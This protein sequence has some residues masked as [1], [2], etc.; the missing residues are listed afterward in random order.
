MYHMEV[1]VT[2]SD[3]LIFSDLHAL[4]W[5]DGINASLIVGSVRQS[6]YVEGVGAEARFYY[7][8]GFTRLNKTRIVVVDYFNHCLRL[9]AHQAQST[10][11]L[12]GECE[13]AGFSDGVESHF[14]Y[15][16]SVI[17]HEHSA[18][19]LIIADQSNH[20]LRVFDLIKGATETIIRHS[21]LNYPRAI[22]YDINKENLLLSNWNYIC[23]YNLKT[24]TLTNI[25]GSIN[26]GYAD[27]SLSTTWLNF[28][29]ELI[30]ITP[31][32]TLIADSENN[33]LRL[34]DTDS[35][36]VTSICAGDEMTRDGSAQTCSLNFPSGFLWKGNLIY[37]GQHRA[38]R[39][40]KCN[41]MYF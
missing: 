19:R 4:K 27:G 24:G 35:D 14:F 32:L 3:S 22:A 23:K 38:I 9:I 26:P 30:S 29:H 13:N 18:H 31:S 36:T 6:G 15:P 21:G 10:S 8:T 16:R 34:V 41:Y 25:T 28:P 17:K 1:D 2:D 20:A 5:T 7:I 11:P 33:R 37:I 39:F 12:A 40:I